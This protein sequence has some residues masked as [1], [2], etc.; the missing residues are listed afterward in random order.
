M[1]ILFEKLL[2]KILF[3]IY[4]LIDTLG[5]IFNILTGTQTADGQ[6]TLL[7]VFAESAV[8]TKVILGLCLVAIVIT[9]ACMGVR[10]A[11]NTIKFKAGG[12]QTSNATVVKLGFF[13]VLSSV[14]CIFFVFMFI[15]FAGMLLNMVNSVIAPADNM[16]LSQN[17]FNLSVEQSYVIDEDKWEIRYTDY[18]DEY[19]NRVQ[20]TDASSPDG[21]AWERD[22]NGNLIL[23][24][25]NRPIEIWVQVQ[26]QY[27]PYKTDAEGNLIIESG[28]CSHTDSCRKNSNG[29]YYSEVHGA[30]CLDWS[31][32]PDMV[33]GVHEK[34]W[35]KLFEQ[36]DKSYTRQPM[37]RLESFNLFT[38][39]LVAIIV[40]ISMFMLSV[41]L[42]KRIYDIIVLIVCMPLVCGTIPLD[43][44]AR[45]R[46]WRETF[47]SKVLVAFGAVIALNV[48]YMISAFI[49]GPAFDLTYFIDNG[50][51]NDTAV[52]I[53]K[54]LLLLGG[55]MCINGSQ[56]LIARILGTSADESREAMQSFATITSGVRL[57]AAGMLG[58][59][60][61]AMGGSRMIFGG[62]NRYGR[63]RTGLVPMAFRGGN[64]IGERVGGENYV[65]SRGGAFV[66]FMGRMGNRQNNNANAGKSAEANKDSGISLPNVKGGL[67]K[68]VHSGGTGSE[69]KSSAAYSGHSVS[70][71]GTVPHVSSGNGNA[72]APVNINNSKTIASPQKSSGSSVRPGDGG[73]KSGNAEHKTSAFNDS[74][75]RGKR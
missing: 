14:V 16:T 32:S 49:M 68:P 40:F 56:V 2:A 55:A 22:S 50:I 4:D 19:G 66:R 6:R 39:Y 20:E 60:R 1:G 65:N 15:S 12:E 45:F 23:D 31:L 3:W 46:A 21:L 48:F 64:A 11:K 54:M 36:A 38:A 33:F 24:D 42:V 62:T 69:G 75:K 8:S 74:D 72:S 25:N 61:V 41:G 58:A 53:F 37:V 28:W 27:H 5:A 17:L 52:T 59:G 67:D 71:P 29:Q 10:I 43:D 26:E 9:G 7:E 47:M 57:G 35:I 51:L 63:Q 18:L 34:D 70:Q 44:G 13:S 73:L 30:A